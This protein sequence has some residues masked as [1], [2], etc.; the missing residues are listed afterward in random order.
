MAGSVRS[1]RKVARRLK[2][3]PLARRE[4]RSWPRFMWCY[5]L[6]IV[7]RRPY[8]F[9]TGARLRIARGVEHVPII[10]IFLRRDYGEVPEDATV[11]D[12]GA[13]TGVF[14][15]YATSTTARSRVISYE[16]MPASFDLLTENVGLN[17]AAAR[18]TAERAGVSG[19]GGDRELIVGAFFPSFMADAPTVAG[20]TE[21]ITVPSV[22]LQ[23]IVDRHGLERVD[24]LKLDIEGAEYEVLYGAAP[25][26][27][28]RI[29]EIR[30][31]A[32]DLDDGRR[33]VAS[34]KRFLGDTG[35]AVTREE[36][37]P[38]GTVALWLARP[39]ADRAD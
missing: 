1:P 11:L 26:V 35:L 31:E 6:G 34:L 24:L 21:T 36:R 2:L 12:L 19:D 9:R 28:D 14:A 8:T 13:S 16:P 20:A 4:V 22:T 30:M 10:E 27:L 37:D 33:N 7:P 25:G 29:S 15:A 3:L 39:G 23:E 17:G 18:V 5:A 38:G 32:H